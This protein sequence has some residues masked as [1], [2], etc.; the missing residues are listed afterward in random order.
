MPAEQVKVSNSGVHNMRST[1][2]GALQNA[3]KLVEA[4]CHPIKAMGDAVSDN[5]GLAANNL[6]SCVSIIA[7]ACFQTPLERS[8]QDP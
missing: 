2:I 1:N 3:G 4:L 5:E 8:Y 6:L 7:M